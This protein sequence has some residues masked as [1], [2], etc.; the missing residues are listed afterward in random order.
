LAKGTYIHSEILESEAYLS[1]KGAAPQVLTLMLLKRQ[2]EKHK[3]KK[4]RVDSVCVNGDSLTFTYIEAEKKYGITQPRLTRAIDELLAKGFITRR[5]H[6]GAYK[7]DKAIYGLS[8]KYLFWK[9][10][11]VIEV[12]EKDPAQRGFRNPKRTEKN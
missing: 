12:R 9:P 6:G 3:L 1:L 11:V 5:H 7:Q 8:D 2:F 10:G 4:G